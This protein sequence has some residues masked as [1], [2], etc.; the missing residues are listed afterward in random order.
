MRPIL[1]NFHSKS[2]YI[3]PATQGNS[4]KSYSKWF[5]IYLLNSETNSEQFPLEECIY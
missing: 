1:F 5:K 4:S 2:V 3:K